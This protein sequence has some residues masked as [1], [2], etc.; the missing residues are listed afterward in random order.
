MK[1]YYSIVVDEELK[2]CNEL[3]KD[4]TKLNEVLDRLL[5]LEQQTYIAAET[6][7]TGCVLVAIVKYCYQAKQWEKM[8]EHII[9][10]SRRR[11]QLKQAITKMVQ[12]AYELV[13]KTPDVDTKLKLIETLRTVTTG[14]IFV[15]NE[16]ARLTKKLADVY[17][18]QDK[19]KEAAEILQELQVEIY[20][21][22][23]RREKLEFLLEQM[24]LCLATH[25][26]IRTQIISKKINIKIFEDG[27]SHDLTL[28]YYEL[29]IEMDLHD[30]NYFHVCQH[31]KHY[32][33]IPSIKQDS[34][35]MKQALKYVV[36]YL[37]LSSYNNE[38]SDFLHRLF[39][40]KN[41][42]K[43]PKYKEILQRFKTQ[44][45]I[46]W[47]DILKSCENELKNGTKE[48]PATNVFIS[49]EDGEK[50]WEEFKV[51]VVEHNMRIMAKY[52]TRVRTRKIAELLDL[53]KEVAEHFL[54]NLV[55]NKIVNAKI[56]RLQDIVTFQEKKSPQEILNEWSTNLDSLMTIINKICHLINK[57]ETVHA[58]Q[59]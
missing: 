4:E 34:E 24:R 7:S 45:L 42:E 33:E 57:E 58:V 13:E 28:K 37:I 5:L 10:L 9:I 1:I 19:T 54:S 18:S 38:Q 20:G 56:D 52:Y 32:Y 2:E 40:D 53:T 44:E 48:D 27:A 23:D 31:Y 30:K 51:R 8:N 16:H 47:K 6:I 39:L 14:K 12:E 15:E 41:L 46:H 21:T 49:N 11:S 50:L 3:M 22:M 35:K 59:T 36:L 17:E 26:F 25:D 55:S 43:I 29:M